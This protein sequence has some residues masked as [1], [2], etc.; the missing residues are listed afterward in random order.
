MTIVPYAE[1]S[2]EKFMGEMIEKY[3]RLVL[4]KNGQRM[5]RDERRKFSAY[6]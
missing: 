1:T 3:V 6:Y 2:E 4:D 5:K